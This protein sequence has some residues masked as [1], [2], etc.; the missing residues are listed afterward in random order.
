VGFLRR[1]QGFTRDQILEAVTQL[2][3]TAST[4][5]QFLESSNTWL[6]E[7]PG[8]ALDA[9]WRSETVSG[10]ISVTGGH[11]VL[12]C[13][14]ADTIPWTAVASASTPVLARTTVPAEL[15]VEVACKLTSLSLG[16]NGAAVG[17]FLQ[18]RVTGDVHLFGIKRNA[19]ANKWWYATILAGVFTET[20]GPTIAAGTSYWLRYVDRSAVSPGTADVTYQVDGTTYDGPWTTLATLPAMNGE[21][22]WCG[23]FMSDSTNPVV[24]GSSVNVESFRLY[25]PR[26]PIVF[27]WYIYRDPGLGGTPD[28]VGAQLVID[29]MQPAHEDGTIT[30]AL[31]CLYDDPNSGYDLTP[32]GA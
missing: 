10:S 9:R 3:D 4:N 8:V 21:R 13:A 24:T 28:L 6:D 12:S 32:L 7:F 23:L 14:A 16:E 2:L 29:K 26:S 17:V 18:N 22:Q 30:A 25:A 27:N 11:A 20:F 5:L 1:V 31:S 19:G 15:G